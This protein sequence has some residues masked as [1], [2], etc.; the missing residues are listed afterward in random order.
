[1][2]E[3]DE[4]PDVPSSSEVGT[5]S[6][7]AVE[8]AR[9]DAGEN[10]ACGPVL[11]C[12]LG[13][14][15]GPMAWLLTMPVEGFF[16]LPEGALPPPD[17]AMEILLDPEKSRVLREQVDQVHYRNTVLMFAVL[18]AVMA[19]VLGLGEGIGRKSIRAMVTGITAGI[20]LGAG[21][22]TV[23][24]IAVQFMQ[25]QLLP[26]SGLDLMYLTLA[27]HAT[28]WII[29]G[30]AVGLAVALPSSRGRVIGRSVAAAITA[31]PF[32]AF[33]FL[34]LGLCLVFLF[35]NP[36]PDHVIPS[37][38]LNRLCWTTVA[39]VMM[40]LFVGTVGRLQSRKAENQTSPGNSDEIS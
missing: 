20:V 40:G 34:L 25:R 13:L 27:L 8:S 19:G 28:A 6:L 1:M 33:L 16:K 29:I 9:P 24:G 5:P 18:G 30:I 12:A 3:F 26:F 38:Q 31:G 2:A 17:K 39:A 36:S 23:A 32:A 14:L 11:L 7:V 15:A 37:G 21:L 22:G 35:N 4:R 10:L